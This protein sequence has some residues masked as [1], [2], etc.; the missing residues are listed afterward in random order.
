MPV[1]VLKLVLLPLL[2]SRLL[3]AVAPS[4][5]FFGRQPGQLVHGEVN[6]ENGPVGLVVFSVGMRCF[7]SMG[8]LVLLALAIL[9]V[10]SRVT[11]GLGFK[12]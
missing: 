6:P 7:L 2:L 12:V 11:K 3:L 1:L 5:V 9:Q 10:P 8:G 4:V